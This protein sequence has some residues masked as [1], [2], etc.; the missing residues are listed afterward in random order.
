[1]GYE[2]EMCLINESDIL[3]E[4]ETGSCS[5]V[6]LD[7]LDSDTEN[8]GI[9]S[10]EDESHSGNESEG[11]DLTIIKQSSRVVKYDVS[12]GNPHFLLG[13]TFATANDARMAISKYSIANST[14][15]KLKPN[16]KNRIRARCK[17]EGCPFELFMSQT[18]KTPNL[19]VK[20][21]LSEHYCVREAKNSLATSK[22]LA[23]EFKDLINKNPNT[24][25]KELLNIAERQMHLYVSRTTC[26][27]AK[28][29]VKNQLKGSYLDQFGYIGAYINII[30]TTNPGSTAELDYS[31]EAMKDGRI[32]F[33]RLYLC[34]DALK[35]GW[36]RGCRPIIGLDGC[37]LKGIVKGQVL[38]A[39]GK[40]ADDQIFPV[41][42]AV[43]NKENKEN[44]TWFLELLGKDLEIAH[45]GNIL[46]II[47]DMQKG[48]VNAVH[49]V[50]PLAEHRYCARHVYA[51][52]SKKWRTGE[53]RKKFWICA[54][55]SF[56][57]EFE[58]N[59][60][61]LGA[62]S[63]RAAE[64]FVAYN[65]QV[66][67]RAFFSNRCKSSMVDNNL[68]E[69]FNATIRSARFKPI[70]SML[71]DIRDDAMKRLALHKEYIAKWTSKWSH[72][73]MQVYQDNMKRA[74]AC[75]VIFNGVSGFEVGDGDDRH[76]VNLESSMCTCR[77]WDVSGIPCS[78][79]VCAM[80]HVKKDPKLFISHW[81]EKSTYIATYE[82]PMQ[83]IPGTK[84]M[85]VEAF[86]RCEPPPF[87]RQPGRPKV[88]R[89]RS[90]TETMRG[91]P[92]GSMGRK[93]VIITCSLCR[94]EGHNRATCPKK[95]KNN[96]E[97]GDNIEKEKVEASK[98]FKKTRATIGLGLY[99]D[100]ATGNTTFNPGTSSEAIIT[101]R[102]PIASQTL[103]SN[104]DAITT[105]PIPNERELRREHQALIL[106]RSSATRRIAFA[107]TGNQSI[108]PTNLPF[109]PP[110][111]KW[112]GHKSITT[113]QLEKQ[114][115]SK[116]AKKS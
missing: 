55:S 31:E 29:I 73:S 37:H 48:L 16:E 3:L 62:I 13:M 36:K 65:P 93:G 114:R 115:D 101:Q 92:S 17:S 108:T 20:K 33:K 15:L 9:E 35:R 53:L 99:V 98:C 86:E 71:D 107:T 102:D 40:D 52:W 100:D 76:V 105:F 80:N 46:T 82:V 22:F 32:V 14:P 69:S 27:R 8:F 96:K 21:F 97:V 84:F 72:S 6:E 64:D 43:V 63:K 88:K 56:K 38:V 12:D 30:K 87:T 2:W 23:T 106:S 47:S 34:F 67:C 18:G 41:A 77:S 79:A 25:I 39:V 57:E 94:E 75:K 58:D 10:S 68:C 113:S 61:L 109:N 44:W 54:W 50:L 11:V 26:K 51:N 95:K 59:L 28:K 19:V 78:H 81:Y 1:M 24:S 111:P 104:P 112:K 83:P 7:F 89:I 91:R 116:K 42:W 5:D 103:S 74:F 4:A 110:G 45:S 49:D 70:I 90:S 66:F 60:K 85:N